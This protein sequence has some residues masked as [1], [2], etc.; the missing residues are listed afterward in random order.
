MITDNLVQQPTEYEK[1]EPGIRVL[2]QALHAID[3]RTFWSCEGHIKEAFIYA[4]LGTVTPYPWI[5]LDIDREDIPKFEEKIQA[6]NASHEN[7]RWILTDRGIHPVLTPEYIQ[8]VTRGT[9]R[10][11]RK[12][13]PLS[14]NSRIEPEILASLRKQAIDLANYL[15]NHKSPTQGFLHNTL[16]KSSNCVRGY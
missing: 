9:N 15:T 3:I 16:L 1:L 10:V 14:L 13:C 4:G 8:Q 6:W 5:L 7:E 12:L 2:V 11:L